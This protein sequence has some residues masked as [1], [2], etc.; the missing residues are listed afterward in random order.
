MKSE[1]SIRGLLRWLCTTVVLGML[2]SLFGAAEAQA[3]VQSF[4][5]SVPEGGTQREALDVCRSRFSNALVGTGGFRAQQ[6][7]VTQQSVSECLGETASASA[8]RACEVSMANIEVDFLV[9]PELRRLGGKWNVAV[10]ALSPSQGAAQ[11]WGDD[12]L[13]D[14]GGAEEAAYAACDS[15]ARAFACRQ[16]V[17]S[18]CGVGFGSGPLLVAPSGGGG[19]AVPAPVSPTRVQVSALDVF[20]T[21]PP[22]V[23]VWIDGREAGTSENQISGVPPGQHE[24]ALKATGYFDHVERLAFAAG[25]PAELKGVRLRKTTATLRVAMV[26]PAE[27]AVWIG[28]RERGRTSG[29]L[30]GIAPGEVEVVLRAEGYRERTERVT[31]AADEERRL[32][33][34]RLVPLPAR[35]TVRANIM[36]AEVVVD[37]IVVGTTTG[38]EDTF[39]VAP[40]SKRVEVRR[41]GYGTVTQT[42]SLRPGGDA[43]VV[44]A[45]ERGRTLTTS[46][47][48]AGEVDANF[49]S[50]RDLGTEGRVVGVCPVG[51]VRIAPGTFVMGSPESE[52]GRGDDELQH[53]VTLTR[54]HCMKATEVTQGEWQALMGSNPSAFQNCG[55]NCPVE[56][57]SWDDA[58]AFANALSRREGLPECYP[59]G[60]FSGLDC[61]GYRLPTEAEWEYAARAGTTAARFGDVDDVAWYDGNSG[62]TTHPVGQKQANAWGLYDMLGNVWEW[63]GD[64]YGAHLDAATDPT[65]AASGTSRVFRG[66]SWFFYLRGARASDRGDTAPDNRNLNL[67]FRL[68]RTSP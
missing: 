34:M 9:V 42:L 11:V 64:W 60:R 37:G 19:A 65:G 25:V 29:P 53:R 12:A 52:T 20:D 33:G 2:G 66:G 24:V 57:V 39:E 58:V 28:G 62:G 8:K 1:R 10:K 44:V 23:S 38:G 26:E 55:E 49:A 45:M 17:A 48:R 63:T 68:V 50:S 46:Q 32:E 3:Q 7:A 30:T 6:D 54:A 15:L 40:A 43:G 35:L 47:G 59:L 41:S 67:G 18:A 51:Y 61:R 27:A 14:E 36:G 5:V 13:R 56:Q 16:G 31:F 21:T 4:F 22:V